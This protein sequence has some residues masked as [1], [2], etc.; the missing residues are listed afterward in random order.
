MGFV[1]TWMSAALAG[2]VPS[3]VHALLTGRDVLQATR[4]AGTL[5]G[6]PGVG[7]GVVAHLGVSAGWVA[8][9]GVV[10]R[11]WPLGVV[12]GAAAGAVIALVDLEVVGR[13]FP[14]VRELPRGAQWADHVV[15][16]AVAGASLRAGR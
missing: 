1:R 8:V 2:G 4:A 13:W 14:A 5:L 3:T 12:G 10:D 15:F 9:L 16:G 11:R 6:G 7:R